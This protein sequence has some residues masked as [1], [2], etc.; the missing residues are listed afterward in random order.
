VIPGRQ[1]QT[2]AGENGTG[3]QDS[4]GRE[5]E[6]LFN[7]VRA[8]PQEE[9]QQRSVHEEQL[10]FAGAQDIA[11]DVLNPTVG[12]EFDGANQGVGDEEHEEQPGAHG[13]PGHP[14]H[15]EK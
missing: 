9:H 5:S 14:S 6:A 8:E 3:Q 2:D 7:E 1:V 15:R 13:E 4:H 11:G 12:A 10:A